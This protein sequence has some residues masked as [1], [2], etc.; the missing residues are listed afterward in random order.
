MKKVQISNKPFNMDHL[1]IIG[2]LTC[3][4]RG[5]QCEL[6]LPT[7]RLDDTRL[8]LYF[9]SFIRTPCGIP[10]GHEQLT[11][12]TNSQYNTRS[13]LHQTTKT[14]DKRTPLV[15][16][17]FPTPSS[18]TI[19]TYLLR[20]WRCFTNEV[21]T[22]IA[23]TTHIS[24]VLLVDARCAEWRFHNTSRPD[25]FPDVGIIIVTSHI[26]TVGCLTRANWSDL[27]TERKIYFN[28]EVNL[29]RRE[30]G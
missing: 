26:V 16:W 22:K 8:H 25:E 24:A 30:M 4:T 7:C 15:L 14:T 23:M 21:N 9:P 11:R 28:F 27:D 3:T 5:N 19:P 29:H 20:R 6:L 17:T 18:L 2:H 10:S 1:V 12:V 13:L